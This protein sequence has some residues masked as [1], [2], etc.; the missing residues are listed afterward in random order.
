M[1]RG[2]I[3][4]CHGSRLRIF[5][6]WRQYQSRNQGCCINRG[7]SLQMIMRALGI[8]LGVRRSGFGMSLP[9]CNGLPEVGFCPAMNYLSG[10]AARLSSI[11]LMESWVRRDRLSAWRGGFVRCFVPCTRY[12]GVGCC[13]EVY[14]LGSHARG[15]DSLTDMEL[16][17]RRHRLSVLRGGLV[18]RLIHCT[19]LPEIGFCHAIN[20]LSSDA[21]SEL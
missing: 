9:N 19:G 10:D 15:F 1:E 11:A 13:H 3:P 7:P 5:W 8:W 20:Y 17:I 2:Q 6:G 21:E 18:R 16:R 14:Y 12:Q 4:T